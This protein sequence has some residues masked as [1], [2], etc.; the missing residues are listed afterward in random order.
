MNR[1]GSKAAENKK[2]LFLKWQYFG[3]FY[4]DPHGSRVLILPDIGLNETHAWYKIALGKTLGSSN[5][6]GHKFPK[7]W[8]FSVFLMIFYYLPAHFRQEKGDSP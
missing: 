8:F 6:V 3:L 1:C 5:S 2:G 4:P 7:S